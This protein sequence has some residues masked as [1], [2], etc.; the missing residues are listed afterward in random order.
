MYII[1]V[2]GKSSPAVSGP[3]PLAAH[4]LTQ[5]RQASPKARAKSHAVVL[6]HTLLFWAEWQLS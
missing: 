2:G 5:G 6:G 4:V 1:W 3:V